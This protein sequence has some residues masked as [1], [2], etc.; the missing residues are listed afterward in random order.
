MK[1]NLLFWSHVA[2]FFLEWTMFQ[3]KALEKTMTHFL[4]SIMFFYF[5]N[6][7]IYEIK[8][9]TMLEPDR[10]QTTWCMRIACWV[11]ET[12]NTRSDYV[13]VFDFPLQKW[14]N[15]ISSVLP[16]WTLPALIECYSK[17]QQPNFFNYKL[18]FSLLIMGVNHSILASRT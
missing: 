16:Y 14:L 10:P 7:A 11:P 6:R 2:H 3:T 9:K 18:K 17:Y 15:I 12:T 13:I 1:T 4:C 5:L 8:W